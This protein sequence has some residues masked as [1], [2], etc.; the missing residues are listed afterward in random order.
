MREIGCSFGLQNFF[1]REILALL[2]SYP[3]LIKRNVGL[4]GEQTV[5]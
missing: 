2:E 1:L 4:K 5:M 3:V